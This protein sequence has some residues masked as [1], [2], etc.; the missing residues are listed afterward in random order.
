MK[1]LQILNI[2]TETLSNIPSHAKHSTRQT[3]LDIVPF[4]PQPYTKIIRLLIEN[5]L[6]M[7][8]GIES[9]MQSSRN[10][11][12]DFGQQDTLARPTE[13][14]ADLTMTTS[15]Q[16]RFNS[17]FFNGSK[18][19]MIDSK[20]S[21]L[22]E[23]ELQ[24]MQQKSTWTIPEVAQYP[25]KVTRPVPRPAGGD[26]MITSS[27]EDDD[28]VS[29]FSQKPKMLTPT[30]RA[31]QKLNH[32]K[33]S[34]SITLEA[35]TNSRS[36]MQGSP[37]YLP[38][39]KSIKATLSEDEDSDQ[40]GSLLPTQDKLGN[41]ATGHFCQFNLVKKFPYKY[42]K[43]ANGRVS[44]HFFANNKFFERTWDL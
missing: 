30:K 39:G 41:R 23:T 32:R 3:T 17:L 8:R 28:Y 1:C 21:H 15:V 10:E 44:R 4:C 7:A 38:N 22:F 43:D 6:S 33:P 20:D 42:M 37:E 26:D 12:V 18:P 5:L 24:Q 31:R 34:G 25:R 40:H 16:D 35:P 36:D 29:A 2:K 11:V 14:E 19:N 9:A 13:T 27:D